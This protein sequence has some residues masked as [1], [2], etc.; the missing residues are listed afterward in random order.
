MLAIENCERCE[1]VND[2]VMLIC[3]GIIFSE[4]HGIIIL[5]CG[6]PYVLCASKKACNAMSQTFPW[7]AR[8]HE[9]KSVSDHFALATVCCLG[10]K[11]QVFLG[12]DSYV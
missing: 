11:L 3:R 9:A 2:H 1:S 8:D 12:D 5:F 6:I 10:D 7:N 4:S